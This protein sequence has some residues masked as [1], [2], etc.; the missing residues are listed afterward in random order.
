MIYS[1]FLLISDKESRKIKFFF[2]ERFVGKRSGTTR[3]KIKKSLFFERVNIEAKRTVLAYNFLRSKRKRNI[4]LT[5]SRTR[6]KRPGCY[7]I[8]EERSEAKGIGP[9][10]SKNEGKTNRCIPKILEN[11]TERSE[12]F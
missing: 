2:S 4:V 1:I 3:S 5:L 12:L 8:L 7:K 6:Q 11:E 9:I 10:L